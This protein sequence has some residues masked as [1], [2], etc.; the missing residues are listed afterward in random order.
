MRSSDHWRIA[1]IVLTCTVLVTDHKRHI[2][3]AEDSTGSKSS[4]DRLMQ[5][6]NW[7]RECPAWQE[8]EPPQLT[9]KE[10]VIA[11]LDAVARSDTDTIREAV[12]HLV[13]NNKEYDPRL[14]SKLFLL[15][16]YIFAVPSRC[17][18]KEVR[19]FGNWNGIPYDDEYINLLWPFQLMAKGTLDIV[20][21]FRGYYGEAFRPLDEFDYFNKKFGRRKRQH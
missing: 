3:I 21:D 8:L 9:G 13:I 19:L 15:N 4:N 20:S 7:I 12:K 14:M 16:R 17:K 5:I 2:A 6:L 18:R 1:A 11:Q 10:K